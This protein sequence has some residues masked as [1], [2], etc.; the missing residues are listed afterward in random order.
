MTLEIQ[1]TQVNEEE[2]ALLRDLAIQTFV[3]AF[4]SQNTA[5]NM[6]TYTDHAFSM[7][8]IAAQFHD[9]GTAFYFARRDNQVIGYLQLNRG[10]AQT[11]SRLNNALEIERIYVVREFQGS[12][13]GAQ[14][15][16]FA[17]ESA[18]RGQFDWLW[19]GVWDQNTRAISFY[20]RHDFEIF[21]DHPFNLGDEPQTDLLLRR[22][23]QRS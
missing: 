11:D 4:A 5:Q 14:L 21:A 19:L 17:L 22:A 12:G 15:I 16:E 8:R 9:P 10:D 7:D 6:L 20:E 2:I 3:D 13:L 1:I 18:K 23:V